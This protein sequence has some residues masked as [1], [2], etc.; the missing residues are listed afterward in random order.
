MARPQKPVARGKHKIK[1][2]HEGLAEEKKSKSTYLITINTN[3][4]PAPALEK[5]FNKNVELFMNIIESFIT[6]RDGYE[7]DPEMNINITRG[8][9]EIGPNLGRLHVHLVVEIA[10]NNNIGIS[11]ELLTQAGKNM[12]CK[13]LNRFVKGAQDL[14][15]ALQYIRKR[16]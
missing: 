7:E 2:E 16:L 10:H 3:R 4:L 12:G 8:L 5:E 1:I 15:R 13:I 6:V 11:G 9:N 14:Q